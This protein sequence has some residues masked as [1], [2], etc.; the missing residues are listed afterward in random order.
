MYVWHIV[1]SLFVCVYEFTLSAS[2][3]FVHSRS[4]QLRSIGSKSDGKSSLKANLIES[5]DLNPMILS[6]YFVNA[7]N[8]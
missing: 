5:S 4:Q 7:W 3:D 2:K 6:Y 1:Q 8:L